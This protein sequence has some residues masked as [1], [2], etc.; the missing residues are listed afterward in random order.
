MPTSGRGDFPFRSRWV[1]PNNLR[2]L[3]FYAD[4][5][6]STKTFME[7]WFF[8]AAPATT[9]TI[10]AQSFPMLYLNKPVKA[11]E[12]ISKVEGATITKVAK[13]FPEELVKSGKAKELKSKWS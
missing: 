9:E 6:Q 13:D 11:E 3:L 8:E 4:A 5:D 2:K 7:D 10:T 1:K 12:L